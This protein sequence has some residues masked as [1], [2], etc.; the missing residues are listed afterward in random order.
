MKAIALRRDAATPDVL[1]DRVMC[2]DVRDPH[3]RVVV[4]KGARVDAVAAATLLSVPWDEIHLLAL[5][6]GDVHEEE[7][8]ERLANAVVGDGVEVKN[9][10]G[11]QWTL[12]ATRNG[13]LHIETAWFIDII[14]T[15]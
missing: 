11:G 10:Y 9:Y 6:P 12:K 3:R 2:H 15:E 8:G 7:A 1:I 4:P 5:D 13:L 14:D